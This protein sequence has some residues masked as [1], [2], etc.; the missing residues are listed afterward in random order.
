MRRLIFAAA[1]LLTAGLIAVPAA[2][3]AAPL[4][5]CG[6]ESC[7]V[8]NDYWNGGANTWAESTVAHNWYLSYSND[9]EIYGVGTGSW[10]EYR[11]DNTTNQC[12]TLDWNSN[13]TD[14]ILDETCANHPSQL[15][16]SHTYGNSYTY[17][18]YNQYLTPARAGCV[19]GHQAVIDAQTPTAG[20]SM[21][22]V[23]T[24]G[25]PL[26]EQLWSW[27]GP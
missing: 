4:T 18:I 19:G 5:I 15:W 21:Q 8:N 23:E 10:Q 24:N 7:T 25:D 20:L 2:A 6:D 27:E 13:G 1:G 9:T 11:D 3:S 22:C 14:K 26:P 12:M 16:A 17:Y